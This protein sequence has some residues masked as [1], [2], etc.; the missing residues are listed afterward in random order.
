[1]MHSK[2]ALIVGAG[3]VGSLLAILL[4]KRGYRVE[5]YERRSDI[6]KAGFTGGRS[7]N[8]AMSN[9]GW[10]ALE[11]AGIRAQIESVAIPMYGRMIHDRTGDLSFQPYGKAGQAIFSVSRAGLNLELL[12]I[13]DSFEQVSIHFDERCRHIDLETNEV[14]FEN[15]RSGARSQVHAPL[16]F[17]TDGAFSAIRNSLQKTNRFNYSQSYLNYG[18]K[19]LNIPPTEAGR[20][21][22]DPNALHIWPRGKFMLIALPNVDGSFTC[23]LFL[24]FEDAT[25]AFAN[26]QTDAQVTVFFATWF[27]DTLPLIP[28]LLEDF[29]QNPVS[30]LVT[31]RCEPWHYN[32][33][34]LL[35]GDAAHAIVPF[36][37]QGMN[38][39]FEDCTILDELLSQYPEN[40][41]IVHFSDTR[42]E[43]ANAIADLALQNF[44][45]MR[46]LVA[47]PQF[48]V[49]K[50]IEIYL[51]EQYPGQFLPVY[52]MVTF[53]HLPYRAA[54][55]EVQA[56]N[57]LFEQ[58]FALPGITENWREQI[59]VIDDVFQRWLSTR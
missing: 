58:L 19:E 47:D 1:M 43:D 24:P 27:A 53:S 40:E 20:H 18:Y 51:A 30:S 2:Q 34:V 57:R 49:R 6:R 54:L 33:R 55:R 4:A 11:Q 12:H 26:L 39:G 38:A 35:L 29:R 37:G 56:Q 13:A 31:I 22:M 10:R 44:I 9:R 14:T 52:A 16:I 23:T 28:D 7:I 48:L 17:G 46:D 25:E 50:D 41:A 3:L 45:E 32:R 42:I 36:F 21:R 8:L 59:A 5:V 15:Q